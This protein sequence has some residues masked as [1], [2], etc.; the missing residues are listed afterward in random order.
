MEAYI[1]NFDILWNRVEISER[2]ALMFFMGGLEVEIK[3][4]VK[5]FELKVFKQVYNLT[6]QQENTLSHYR[7]LYN[8]LKQSTNNMNQ[9]DQTRFHQYPNINRN[10]SSLLINTLK[11]TSTWSISY[12]CPKFHLQTKF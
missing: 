1:Q 5:I 9:I 6:S 4:L 11:L 2:E 3:N 8:N 7:N 12:T 10:S